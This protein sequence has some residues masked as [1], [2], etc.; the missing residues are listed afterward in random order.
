MQQIINNTVCPALGI[1]PNTCNQIV[2]QIPGIIQAIENGATPQQ[3]CTLIGLCTSLRI[4]KDPT[5]C[6]ICTFA[7]GQVES[8]L[9][10]NATETEIENALNQAC[11]LLGPFTPE[12]NQI[13]AQLPAVIA[14]LE[15]S[16]PPQVACTQLGLCVNS[17]RVAPVFVSAQ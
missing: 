10:S 7:V 12:C 2:Q 5:Q 17:T 6:A 9:S 4:V 11:M 13:V 14:D 15:E 8:Y 16:E 1:D 3:V